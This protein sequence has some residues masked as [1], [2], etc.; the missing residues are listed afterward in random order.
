MNP[1]I[2]YAGGAIRIKKGTGADR[3][4]TRRRPRRAR[5]DGAAWIFIAPA[6]VIIVGFMV[7]P[8]VQSFWY[9]LHDWHIGA[10]DQRW[11][12]SENYVD[13]FADNRF[14]NA[15]RVTA[16]FSA[17][18][19]VL[20]VVL[21]YA[22]AAALVRDTFMSRFA[23]SVFFFPTIVATAIVGLVWSFLLDPRIGLTGG[24]FSALGLEPIGWLQ[25]P[26][27]ALPAVIFV[28][29]WKTL[30]F[31]MV[32]LLAGIKGVPESLY[33]AARIDGAKGLQLTRY[34]TLP[35]IRPTLLFVVMVTTIRCFE[36]FD[37]VFVMT[38]GGPLFSTDSL[39]NFVVREGIEYFNVGYASAAT[40]ILFAIMIMLSFVQLRIFRYRDVD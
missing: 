15:L 34:I 30:G 1:L 21:G 38:G 20:L 12:G 17:V 16:A 2:S 23:R 5:G 27:L 24:L 19:V 3:P 7:L 39:I 29:V 28:N 22:V 11:T 35:S 33:E 6:M 25:D 8:L 40:L 18:S 37:L 14:W 10:Q 31:T 32:I 9:S 4:A 26:D 36:V 13:L